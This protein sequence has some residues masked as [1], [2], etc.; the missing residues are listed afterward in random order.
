MGAGRNLPDFF[1]LCQTSQKNFPCKVSK[2]V[3]GGGGYYKFYI[4][5]S[6]FDYYIAY[7]SPNI[8]REFL[9][10][11]FIISEYCPTV[12]RILPDNL[13]GGQP[14]P[15]PRPV[16][17][18]MFPPRKLAPSLEPPLPPLLQASLRIGHLLGWG[19][20]VF[21]VKPLSIY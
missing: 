18:C 16:R 3:V 21:P 19:G 2:I 8:E 17:I 4:L 1:P 14:P 13:R 15:A 7:I 5:T 20:G 11:I 10:F 12:K 9:L 6:I